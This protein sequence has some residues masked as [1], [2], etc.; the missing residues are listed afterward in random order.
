MHA[1]GTGMASG[2]S[3]AMAVNR[4]NVRRRLD[5]TGPSNGHGTEQVTIGIE[6][7]NRVGHCGNLVIDRDHINDPDPEEITELPTVIDNGM[8]DAV[9]DTLDNNTRTMRFS[10][11]S[12]PIQSN[13]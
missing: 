7:S 13:Y 3:D 11:R 8:P 10:A 1:N 4:N 9:L 6:R 2:C 5:D 12:G